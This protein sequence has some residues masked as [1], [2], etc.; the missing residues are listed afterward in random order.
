MSMKIQNFLVKFLIIDQMIYFKEIYIKLL[1]L[2]D[3]HYYF[4][5]N[6]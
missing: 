4:F 6:F 1:I 3:N 2:V 5:S